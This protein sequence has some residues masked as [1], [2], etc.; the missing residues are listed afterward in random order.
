MTHQISKPYIRLLVGV[1]AAVGLAILF[2]PALAHGHTPDSFA[3][4]WH[5]R[6]RDVYMLTLAT[7][8]VVS[9]VSVLLRGSVGQRLVAIAI[10]TLPTYVLIRFT[11]WVVALSSS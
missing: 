11:V 5:D 4:P 7:V 8:A 3:H 9:V 1:V 6:V 2:V 10:V